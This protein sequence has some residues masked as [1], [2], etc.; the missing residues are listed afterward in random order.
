TIGTPDAIVAMPKPYDVP[1]AGT[2]DYQYFSA[3]TGFSEDKWV[4][5]IEIRPGARNV[6]HHVL[7]FASEPGET[8]RPQPFVQRIAGGGGALA[9]PVPPLAAAASRNTPPS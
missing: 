3:P 9:E 2:I 6:V 7:V 1:A 5:A 4:Q 8:P